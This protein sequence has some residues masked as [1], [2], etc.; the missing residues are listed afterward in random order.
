MNPDNLLGSRVRDSLPESRICDD[1]KPK[2][3]IGG[4]VDFWLRNETHSRL[5]CAIFD[6]GIPVST[7]SLSQFT[8]PQMYPC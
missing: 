1:G 7:G 6:V 8:G 4:I 3:P 5:T 2:N